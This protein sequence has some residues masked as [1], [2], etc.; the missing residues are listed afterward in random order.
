[1][2]LTQDVD[3]ME[4]EVGMA[5]SDVLSAPV[6]AGPDDVESDLGIVHR[7]MLG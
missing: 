3:P 5:R 7:Q 1:M 2:D 6:D 4:L